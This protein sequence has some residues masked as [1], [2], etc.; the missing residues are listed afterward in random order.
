MSCIQPSAKLVE[1][2]VE[3]GAPDAGRTKQPPGEQ[4]T[5]ADDE[6]QSRRANHTAARRGDRPADWP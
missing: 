6:A 2:S 4:S 3:T 5:P 1:R